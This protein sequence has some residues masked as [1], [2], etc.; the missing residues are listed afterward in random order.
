[1][2]LTDTGISIVACVAGG[3]VDARSKVLAAEPRKPNCVSCQE[4]GDDEL[5]S[6]R[7]QH[8]KLRRLFQFTR[9]KLARRDR[10]DTFVVESLYYSAIFSRC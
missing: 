7:L 3:I 1:M 2:S 5:Y 6:A 10:K 4:N 9:V 8:R